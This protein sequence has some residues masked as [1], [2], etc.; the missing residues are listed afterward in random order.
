MSRG[1]AIAGLVTLGVF[2]AAALA[3]RNASAIVTP[4]T[5]PRSSSPGAPPPAFTPPP[6]YHAMRAGDD[7]SAVRVHMA[8][9]ER[10]GPSGWSTFVGDDGKTYGVFVVA[11][12]DGTLKAT[13]Y[14]TSSSTG[15][16]AANV[17]LPTHLDH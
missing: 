15:G 2:A 4:R 5:L 9:L 1:A 6:G 13:P 12:S 3:A 17:P 11:D 7:T 14:T 8:E 10:T 16:I